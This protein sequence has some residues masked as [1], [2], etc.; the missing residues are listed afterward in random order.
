MKKTWKRILSAV[1]ALTL[2]AIS[3]CAFAEPKI[4]KIG[5]TNQAEHPIVLAL[6][7]FAELVDEYTDGSINVE[8]YSDGQLG[9]ERDLIEGCQL[10]TLYMSFTT[11]G[12][13]SSFAPKMDVLS[14]PYLFRDDDHANGVLFGEIGEELSADLLNYG[15][16]NLAF[17]H[18]GWRELTNSV[19]EINTPEDLNGLKIRVM[20]SSVMID[21]LNAMGASAVPMGWSEVITSLQQGIIDGQEN[22]VINNVFNGAYEVQEYL[23]M[24]NHFFGPSIL[25]VNE[26]WYQSLT[27]EEQDAL[28]RAAQEAGQYQVELR[29]KME[30]EALE[31]LVD[32]FGLKIN[33]TPDLEAFA[34]AV[35]P[36]YEKYAETLGGWDLINEIRNYG[37]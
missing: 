8:V 29:E 36:V 20:E 11:T 31:D 9:N 2:L 22:P 32:R 18:T 1:L 27:S 28:S 37:L 19:R 23:S 3:T 4:V 26:A 17:W 25:L 13:V 12:P 24:T 33:Y 7:H 14:L 30:A 34:A 10:G 5:T 6:K 21:T 15:M 35:E 16:R